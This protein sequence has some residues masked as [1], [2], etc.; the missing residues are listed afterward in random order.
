MLIF[1]KWSLEG[2]TSF[3]FIILTQ[4]C[5]KGDDYKEMCGMKVF[6]FNPMM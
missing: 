2:K 1:G 3:G 6:Y 4:N 5:F